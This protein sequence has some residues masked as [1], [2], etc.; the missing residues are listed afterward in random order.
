MSSPISNLTSSTSAE[1]K[2]VS[3]KKQLIDPKIQRLAETRLTVSGGSTTAAATSLLHDLDLE[4]AKLPTSEKTHP[5]SYY[6]PGE[7]PT[8]SKKSSTFSLVNEPIKL[9]EFAGTKDLH[10][11]SSINPSCTK[12]DTLK[13]RHSLFRATGFDLIQN[14]RTHPKHYSVICENLDALLTT[15]STLPKDKQKLIA[16]GDLKYHI[17]VIKL[18]LDPSSTEDPLTIM[19]NKEMSDGLVQALRAVTS[20]YHLTDKD[21]LTKLYLKPTDSDV[22]NAHIK[23]MSTMT[24]DSPEGRGLE[25]EAISDLFEINF[26]SFSFN[27]DAGNTIEKYGK[28]PKKD[29]FTITTLVSNQHHAVLSG[30][31]NTVI[32]LFLEQSSKLIELVV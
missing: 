15:F 11:F 30:L 5:L 13:D 25:C 4:L 8:A 9:S 28:G 24:T 6:L 10:K 17:D 27:K 29:S 31:D 14:L 18:L 7:I 23:K 16:D 1:V 19:N 32:N 12:T 20:A 2:P 22:F 3:D 26:L 21:V